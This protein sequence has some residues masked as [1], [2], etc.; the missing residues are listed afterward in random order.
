MS[1]LPSSVEI[2][3]SLRLSA[4]YHQP[5]RLRE[6]ITLVLADNAGHYTGPGTNTYLVGHNRLWIIDPGPLNN[7]HIEAVISAV[8][9]R[10]VAGIL[11]THSHLDHSPAGALLQQKLACPIY[12][13]GVLDA[14]LVNQTDED[15]DLDFKPDILVRDGDVL[16][17]ADQTITALHTPGHFPNH[18]AYHLA[19]D[20]IL[21]TGDHIMGWSTTVI[22]PPLGNLADYMESLKRLEVIEAKIML[23]S[24][25]PLIENPAKRCAELRDH[26][27]AR[28]AM[29]LAC[30][31]DGMLDPLVIRDTIYPDLPPRLKLA[32]AAQVQAHLNYADRM[33]ALCA[34]PGITGKSDSE[35]VYYNR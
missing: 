5:L 6:N 19:D 3:K 24:H 11:V 17:G 2:S 9:R 26:R 33:E 16:S 8:D 7:A 34:P 22:V 28:H 23:P 31:K 35:T 12:G 27:F 32:A 20:N 25:G 10:P 21:F 14:G 18:V 15:I 1:L 29:I 30:L 13:Q 4:A